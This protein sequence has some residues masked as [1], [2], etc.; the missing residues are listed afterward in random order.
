MAR[1]ESRSSVEVVVA[2]APQSGS[3]RE[4]DAQN[5]FVLAMLIVLVAVHSPWDFDPDML[6]FWLVLGYAFG[7][8]VSTRWSGPRRLLTSADR[9]RAQ[10]Q[11]QAH[12]LFLE[13]RVHS[14][15]D[16]S[17]LLLFLSDFERLAVFVP[18]LGVEAT[19]PRAELNNLEAEWAKAKTRETFE[20]AVLQGLESLAEPLASALPRRD[21]DENELANEVIVT[22]ARR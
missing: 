11:T 9:R 1:L 18:D 17:G 13:Q 7:M 14:T 3:Y 22:G 5:G 16:R 21:D 12:A 19:L 4:L 8:L 15:R 6:L 10:V 2:V 20:Q